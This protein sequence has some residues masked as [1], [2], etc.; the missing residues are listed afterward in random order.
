[1]KEKLLY[2]KKSHLKKVVFPKKSSKLSEL[3]G[4]IMGDGEISNPWQV[5]ISLNSKKDVQFSKYVSLLFKEL[6][7]VKVKISKRKGEDC[8][9]VVCSSKSVVDF[10]VANGAIRGN[11]IKNFISIPNWIFRSC[12]NS[13]TFVRGLVDTD[14][15]LYVHKHI[16]GKKLQSNLGFCFTSGSSSLLKLVA[17]VFVRNGIKPHITDKCRRIY[18]YSIKDIEEYLK[19][20]GSSNDRINKL[21]DNWKINKFQNN[22]EVA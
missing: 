7:Q 22:G 8:L 19:K 3:L 15:C 17:E 20:F 18:L 21:F 9:K 13:Q 10:L 16:A 4:I 6:F 5:I 14:G 12:I 2:P 1:M 11:K